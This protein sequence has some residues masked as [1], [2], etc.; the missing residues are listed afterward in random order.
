[1]FWPIAA[2][3]ALFE[4]ELEVTTRNLKFLTERQSI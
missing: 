2:A 3:S 1:M 4:G